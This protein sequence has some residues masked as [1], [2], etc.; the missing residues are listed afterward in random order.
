MATI[1]N[2]KASS[3]VL[4]AGK[5]GSGKTW[6]AKRLLWNVPRLVF[7]DAKSTLNNWRST[8]FSRKKWREFMEGAE[9]RWR[10]Q[11]PI[12]DDTDSWYERLFEQLYRAKDLTLYIDE[13]YAVIPPGNRIGKW[14][15]ALITR[16]RER[17]IGVWAA[18]QRPTWIPLALISEADYLFVFR[19]QLAADRLRLAEIGGELLTKQVKHPHG[20]YVVDTSATLP[21]YYRQAIDFNPDKRYTSS[22][23]PTLT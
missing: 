4:I 12:V 23:E 22:S 3:R 16:G 17:N 19:L 6:L 13:V 11:V 5:T 18:T 7:I 20:F 2:L 10:I 8:P 15:N 9:G 21:V 14:L 1:T